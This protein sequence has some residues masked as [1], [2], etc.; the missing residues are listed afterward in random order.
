[1]AN[2]THADLVARAERWLRNTKRCG[3]V[4]TE[5]TTMSLEIPDAVG[6]FNCG[7]ETFLVECKATVRDFMAD[8]KKIFRSRPHVGMGQFRYYMTP[9]GL[10]NPNA[11]P[12][13]WGLLEVCG[14]IVRVVKEADRFWEV[15]SLAETGLLYSAMRRQQ[16]KQR[17]EAVAS[18]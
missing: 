12:D 18:V 3:V 7:R 1:M 11:V 10:L 16:L 15:N 14:K 9:K 6:W 13:L 5:L 4:V 8:K 17:Q 2:L